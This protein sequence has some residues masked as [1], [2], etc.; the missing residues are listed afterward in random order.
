MFLKVDKVLLYISLCIVIIGI[1]MF[2]SASLG[3]ISK[4]TDKFLGVLTSQILLGVGGGG[5]LFI[6]TL[7]T[8]YTKWKKFAPTLFIISVIFLLL[9]YV[10]GLGFSHG[11]ATRWLSIFG[12]SFQPAE[13]YKVAVVIFTASVM[14]IQK[15]NVND[16]KKGLLP[17]GLI[18]LL[19]A[20][21]LIPQPDTKSLVLIITAIG[22]MYLSAGLKW[23]YITIIVAILGVLLTLLVVTR[24]Y[25]MSRFTTFLHP[26]LDP[27]G[28]SWQLR[29]SLT[30]VGSGGFL[31]RGLGQSLQKFSYLPEPQGDSIFAVVG[32]ELGFLGSSIIVILYVFFSLRIFKNAQFTKD[33]FGKYLLIGAGS[34][35]FF[36]SFMNIG[37][38]IGIIPLTGVPLVFMSHGGTSLMIF[39]ALLGIIMN[40]TKY[41]DIEV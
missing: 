37:S 5:I 38:S 31:G 30:A 4:D 1:L 13:L 20:L 41:S 3:I 40:I 24:P 2:T 26:D 8:R 35:I 25:V 11:G 12:F 16:P 9:L 6:A 22:A 27:T 17:A 34:L 33:Y 21:L 36:Q 32:E 28:S 14:S 39:L 19:S 18:I 10:P 15:G 29:Q 7:R 23:K